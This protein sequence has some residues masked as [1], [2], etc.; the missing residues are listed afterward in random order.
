MPLAELDHYFIRASDLERSRRFYCDLL[1]F[2]VMPRPSLPFPGY[3]LG[4]GG[5]V[6]VHMGLDGFG[7]R[8]DYYPGTRAASARDNSGVVDH[9]A[10]RGSDPAPL[11][12]RLRAFGIAARWRHIAEIGLLQIFVADPDGLTIE[13]NFPGVPAA[14]DW[15]ADGGA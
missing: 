14:P 9:I 13:M 12:Q 2:E 1:G 11:W 3:W 15:A 4:V 7:G 8:P 10:F 5:K 6:Q